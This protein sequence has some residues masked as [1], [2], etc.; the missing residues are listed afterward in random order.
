MAEDK[1]IYIEN[2][3]NEDYRYVLGTKGNNTLFCLG[4]NPSTAKPNALDPTLKRVKAIAENN[5]Y[6]SF[7]MLNVYPQRATN[8]DNLA[9][10]PN[11]TEHR[12]NL[13]AIVTIISQYLMSH[14]KCQQIDLWVSFGNLLTKRSYLPRCLKAIYR[15]LSNI[16]INWLATTI[17]MTNA[18]MHP[19]FE[20]KSAKLISFDM[21]SFINSL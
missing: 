5:D 14:P 1:S 13:R 11:L 19:L 21:A 12:I 17:N 2:P 9:Q 20:A 15:N 6:D 7:V 10:K 4:I 3:Y 18:P 8:P 16:N